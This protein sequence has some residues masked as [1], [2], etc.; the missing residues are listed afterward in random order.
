MKSFLLSIVTRREGQIGLA[1]ALLTIATYAPVYTCSFVNYDDPVYVTENFYVQRGLTLEDIAWSF[2]N[3]EVSNWHPLTWLSLQMDVDIYNLTATVCQM[4]AG[5]TTWTAATECH[6]TNLILHTLNVLLLYGSLV[7]MTGSWPRPALVAALFAV[8]P[9]HVE[10]VAWITE[11]KDVLSTFFGLLTLAAY[12][13][14]AQRP[15]ATRY[16]L[17]LP[18]YAA[19]LLAKQMLVTLPFLLLL[20]D[21]W[22]LRRLDLG[23]QPAGA[24]PQPPFPR[25]TIWR[26]LIEKLPLLAL[27]LAAC[28]AAVYAQNEAKSV[29]SLEDFPL[30]LRL[31]NVV[32]SITAYLRQTVW[33]TDLAVFYPYPRSGLP[34]LHVVVEALLLLAVTLL[35]L[36]WVRT[37]PY[38]LVGWLWFLGTLA[39]VIGI[40]QIGD[41][42]RADRYLYFPHIGLF[43][44]V[45]WGLGELLSGRRL[46]FGFVALLLVA[47]CVPLTHWQIRYWEN[48]HTLWEH[49]RAVTEDNT[50]AR[51]NYGQALMSLG[52]EDEACAEWLEAIRIDPRNDVAQA[53]LGHYYMRHQQREKA[54]IHYR[55]ALAARPGDVKY[56]SLV[57]SPSNEVPP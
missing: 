30:G 27:A 34:T 13:G 38:L 36:C 47:P 11:R 5:Q 15:S 44:A 25:A 9:Q 20:L 51:T 33:P 39:P 32:D 48:S 42:A 10:S 57:K 19:S 54:L 46:L 41:Q 1:L 31:S 49:A 56:L 52:R 53:S 8:H 43:L 29:K 2:T 40:V 55:A 23:Q 24:E 50:V 37:R 3:A 45:V 28:A 16:L 18:L 4:F 6:Q 26:L 35:A 22:P 21:W 17:L 12:L 7:R 14:Y